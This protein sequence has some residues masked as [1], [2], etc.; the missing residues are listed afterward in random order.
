MQRIYVELPLFHEQVRSMTL[1]AE[2]SLTSV[3]K[4][5]GISAQGVRAFKRG[6]RSWLAVTELIRLFAALTYQ[7]IPP[8]I[9]VHDWGGPRPKNRAAPEIQ[10][11]PPPAA[12][13]P[14]RK[15]PASVDEFSIE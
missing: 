6:D 7:E 8:G 5:A 11:P 1:E 2:G 4:R 14:A 15:A 10:K 3:A 9:P 12:K 13:P